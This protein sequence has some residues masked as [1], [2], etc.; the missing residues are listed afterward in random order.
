MCVL[1]SREQPGKRRRGEEHSRCP[2]QRQP[3]QLQRLKSGQKT[4]CVNQFYWRELPQRADDEDD[5]NN[6]VAIELI[7]LTRRVLDEAV[8]C[9]HVPSPGLFIFQ[10]PAL[11]A[12]R[13]MASLKFTTPVRPVKYAELYCRNKG[14]FA[15]ASTWTW[16]S[17]LGVSAAAAAACGHC[18]LPVVDLVSV[19]RG[20]GVKSTKVI[21]R[22]APA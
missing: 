3:C 22:Y 1:S 6:D 12:I 15:E 21:K 20:R 5:D 4:C 8:L 16:E 14:Y 9:R 13:K 2:G 19:C 11:C 7:S 17:R 10:K 18:Q